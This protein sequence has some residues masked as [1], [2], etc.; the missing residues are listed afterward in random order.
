M[1]DRQKNAIRHLT[2]LDSY[3]ASHSMDSILWAREYDVTNNISNLITNKTDLSKDT[4][5][6]IVTIFNK[7]EEAEHF[8]GSGWHDYKIRLSGLFYFFGYDLKWDYTEKQI[9]G[10]EEI[11]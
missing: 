4:F 8:N 6:Q 10:F 2:A 11:I 3:F 5:N 7:I 9:I 1:T